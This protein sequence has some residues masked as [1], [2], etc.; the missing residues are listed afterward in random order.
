MVDATR[1]AYERRHPSRIASFAGVCHHHRT[2]ARNNVVHLP[3]ETLINL[4]SFVEALSQC[5]GL[6]HA[7]SLCLID[8]LLLTQILLRHLLYFLT[9]FKNFERSLV[10]MA[11]TK[12]CDSAI[13]SALLSIALCFW[14]QWLTLLSLH[15]W[16]S[17][18]DLRRDPQV[19]R[20]STAQ[21]FHRI[22]LTLCI[23]LME[24]LHSER[25]YKRIHKSFTGISGSK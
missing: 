25:L 19:P 14:K 24:R 23:D 2:S 18:K 22:Q 3:L 21:R 11:P 10:R 16:T 12:S 8:F 17:W 15:P 7:K 13:K 20:E 5:L 1:G 6:V 4:V 9:A